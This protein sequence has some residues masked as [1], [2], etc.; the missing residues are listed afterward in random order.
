MQLYLDLEPAEV[1]GRAAQYFATEWPYG[2]NYN[3]DANQ[4]RLVKDPPGWQKLLMIPTLFLYSPKYH[5]A[6][7]VATQ[8]GG[9]TFVNLCPLP[10]PIFSGPWTAGPNAN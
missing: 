10:G 8:S 7:V 6:S 5:S 1:L 2:G 9:R 3:V 4:V